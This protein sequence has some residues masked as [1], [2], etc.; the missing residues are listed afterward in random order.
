M[1]DRSEIITR[2]RRRLFWYL[3]GTF[4]FTRIAL[5]SMIYLRRY[6]R[7]YPIKNFIDQPRFQLSRSINAVRKIIEQRENSNRQTVAK[8]QVV[9]Q[10]ILSLFFPS[11]IAYLYYSFDCHAVTKSGIYAR[12]IDIFCFYL[13]VRS[14]LAAPMIDSYR[15]VVG[16]NDS[17]WEYGATKLQNYRSVR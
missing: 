6:S 12:N 5:H 1:I 10:D 15:Q 17:Q 14:R 2:R 13:Y 9:K 11:F 7:R 8:L 3:R 4:S 16:Q